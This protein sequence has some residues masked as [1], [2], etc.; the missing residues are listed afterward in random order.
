[1][2]IGL[3]DSF[4]LARSVFEW[5]ARIDNSDRFLEQHHL[6]DLLEMPAADRD[7]LPGGGG[8]DAQAVV[9]ERDFGDV[10]HVDQML[11]V[12]P[13]EPGPLLQHLQG[14]VGVELPGGG[15]DSVAGAPGVGVLH[16]PRAHQSDAF[17]RLAGNPGD[18]LGLVGGGRPP[19]EQ[20]LDLGHRLLQPLRGHR[21]EQVVQGPLLE[22]LEGVF[23]VGRDEDHVGHDGL[24]DHVQQLEAV[25]HRHLD[26]QEDHVGAFAVD[27][28]EGVDGVGAGGGHV[29]LAGLP[30]QGL[31]LLSRV[32]LVVD[33]QRPYHFSTRLPAA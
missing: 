15:D 31:H 4:R 3:G 22:G 29:D 32:R 6:L 8:D 14:D 25:D 20:V 33:D 18:L 13:D 1:M 12:A 26:V 30:Q 28:L 2:G 24:V 11:L 23:V 16:L 21:L 19:A 10:V 7:A 9:Q 5:T 27:C 17:S